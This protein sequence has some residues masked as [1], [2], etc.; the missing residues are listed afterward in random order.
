MTTDLINFLDPALAVQ[1]IVAVGGPLTTANLIRA[2]R[3][4]IFPWPINDEILPWC[5][6]EVR[7]VLDFKDLH[8][9]RRLARLQRQ[10]KFDFT[11]DKAFV[12]VIE[13]C[14]TIERKDQAGTWITSK[15]ID[16]YSQLHLEGHA[17]SV[18]V[19][20]EYNLVGG[21]YGVD[22]GGAFAG[23]SMFTVVSDASKLALLFL[24]DHLKARGLTWIDIQM[25]T[26]HMAAFGAKEIDREEFLERLADAQERNL[27][28]F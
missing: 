15:I 9:S 24:L 1:G 12:E 3:K 16:A 4:G 6:P 26:P 27:K 7:A 17:H 13:C 20:K 23:E 8:V 10:K 28:L 11:I 18:E 19:W 14:S 21:L 2:Y 25:M 22:S 5:C